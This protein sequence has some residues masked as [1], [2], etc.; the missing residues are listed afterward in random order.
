MYINTF[1]SLNYLFTYWTYINVFIQ[2]NFI[3]N[4]N[5]LHIFFTIKYYPWIRIISFGELLPID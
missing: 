4:S 2:S 1:P 5:C 3:E